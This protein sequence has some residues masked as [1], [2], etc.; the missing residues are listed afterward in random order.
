MV[1]RP[2]VPLL[3]A[4]AC[5]LALGLTGLLALASPG[6]HERDA[7]MLHGF[8][9]LD[10]PRVHWLVE[11]LASLADPLPYAVAGLVLAG[12]AVVQ[13]RKWR[14]AA[15][16]ALLVVTGA[17]TQIVKQL[18]A[19]P[20]VEAWL[21][22]DQIGDA[23]WPS[24]HATAAMTL[25]LCA[26]LVVPP[27]LRAVTALAGGL[28]AAGVGY[29]VIVLAW[30]YP[31]D[32]LGG[33]L[34]ASTWTALAI[35]GLRVMEERPAGDGVTV[36]WGPQIRLWLAA[37]AAAFAAVLVLASSR[38]GVA[39]YAAERPTLVLGAAAIAVLSGALAAGLARAA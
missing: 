31:S 20:R 24:G 29:A 30:H 28:F 13:G 8:M 4:L 11:A 12:A 36:E 33:F 3:V 34:M 18:V 35:S 15:V 25:A 39:L 32:V 38:D 17:S 26:V 7:A 2:T 5:L 22:V 21:P 23:A 14:A 16:V 37:G 19:Q 9:A 10:R 1:R 27:A 6:F